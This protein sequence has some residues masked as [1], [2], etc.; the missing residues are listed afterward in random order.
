MG[1][2][3]GLRR[4]FHAVPK[5]KQA[6]LWPKIKGAIK[7]WAQGACRTRRKV[8][9]SLAGRNGVNTVSAISV[10]RGVPTNRGPVLSAIIL[11]HTKEM[12]WLEIV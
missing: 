5:C 1:K 3:A 6:Q 11:W 4:T 10:P 9:D 8:D 12:D 7:G 2:Q